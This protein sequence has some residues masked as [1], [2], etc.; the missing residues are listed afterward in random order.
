LTLFWLLFAIIN[1]WVPLRGDFAPG[2]AIHKMSLK[3]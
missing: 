2:V 1:G 3:V